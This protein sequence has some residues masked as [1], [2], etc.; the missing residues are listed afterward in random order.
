V[1]ATPIAQDRYA[2]CGGTPLVIDWHLRRHLFFTFEVPTDAVEHLLPR[3]LSCVEVK[4]GLSLLSVGV[5]AYHG[6]HF[7]DPTSPPFHEIVCVV[8]VP[9]DLSVQMPVPRFSFFAVTVYSDSAGFV[10]QEART[11]YTPT[12]LVPS[13]R[14]DWSPDCTGVVVSDDR[15]PIVT[16]ENSHPS[17]VYTPTEFHGQH[18]TLGGGRLLRGIF[19]WTGVRFEH[20]QRGGK[21]K[22]HPHPFWKSL[23]VRRVG[24]TYTQ[25]M[26]PPDGEYHERFYA[27]VPPR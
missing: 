26:A 3:E 23:D 11:I 12:E 7:G 27:M 2:E 19:N 22:L 18:Y 1:N 16:L 21:S 15:G 14:C 17:P 10:E 4:P 6:G 24:G 8:H 20:M 5:L 13:L 25:M 9:P